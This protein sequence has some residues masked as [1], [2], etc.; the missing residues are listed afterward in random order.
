M[1]PV[2]SRLPWRPCEGGWQPLSV[3]GTQVRHVNSPPLFYAVLTSRPLTRINEGILSPDWL[4]KR[5]S[6]YPQ[7]RNTNLFR[8]HNSNDIKRT[9][10]S[11]QSKPS[12]TSQTSDENVHPKRTTPQ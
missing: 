3:F 1:R 9:P 4:Q 6:S 12:G 8:V 2:T 10:L 7:S 5:W 11:M